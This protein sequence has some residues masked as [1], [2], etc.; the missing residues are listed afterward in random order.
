MLVQDR[1]QS[2]DL[3]SFNSIRDHIKRE[4][5]IN[6]TL[7]KKNLVENRLAKRVRENNFN[8]FSD[9]HDY[10]FSPSGRSELA[11][12][13]DYLSTNKTY[14]YREHAHFEFFAK[15][16]EN[17]GANKSISIW[18]AASSTGDEAYTISML[19]NE[20]NSRIPSPNISYN[21]L[22]TDISSEVLK[23]A[24]A[25]V[26][27]HPNIQSLPDRL[28]KKY[29]KITPD[30]RGAKKYTL[31]EKVKQNVRFKKLNLTKEIPSVA[32]KF[33]IIFCR[34]VLIYFDNDTKTKVC[35]QLTNA[36]KPGGYLILG[37][38]E[39]FICR[40]D[41]M[42]QIQPAVFQKVR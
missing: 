27:S 37:H 23:K 3:K 19:I 12:L 21:I 7:A 38:C 41:T 20:I 15:Y 5:G 9:Y 1:Q 11:L 14:F 28:V 42:K 22:G 6:L 36:L 39:G 30:E 10:I 33:D 32:Q 8:S 31:A 24:D 13:S 17:L 2:I 29:F 16:L 40:F 25:A 35:Q 34:N 18:S 4:Y 26:Y